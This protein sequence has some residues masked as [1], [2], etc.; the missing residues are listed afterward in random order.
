MIDILQ[1]SFP[2]NLTRNEYATKLTGA[3]YT[4]N[5]FASLPKEGIIHSYFTNYTKSRTIN[6]RNN[7]IS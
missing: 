4:I 2:E 3:L 5:S 7:Q 6:D 1:L